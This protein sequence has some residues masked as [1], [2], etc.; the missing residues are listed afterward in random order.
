MDESNSFKS[1]FH[2]FLDEVEGGPHSVEEVSQSLKQL[3]DF[4]Q[5]LNEIDKANTAKEKKYDTKLVATL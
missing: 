4:V 3:A 2:R 1:N 5:L